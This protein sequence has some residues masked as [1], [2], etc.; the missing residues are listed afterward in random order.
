M[1]RQLKNYEILKDRADIERLRQF[2]TPCQTHRDTDIDFY[3][4]IAEHYVDVL[5]PCVIAV[6]RDG[7]PTAIV[8]G[9]LE[10]KPL[11]VKI[12]YLRFRT[13]RLRTLT[14]LH[15]CVV[16]HLSEED[17]NNVV[18]RMLDF[19]RSGEAT[20]IR[21]EAIDTKSSLYAR[22]KTA[23]SF[24]CSDH[25]PNLTTHYG[26]SCDHGKKSFM[27]SLSYRPRHNYRSSAKRL[28]EAFPGKVRIEHFDDITSIDRLVEDAETVASKTYQRALGVGF[29]NSNRVRQR[30][31]FEARKN[32]LRSYVLYIEEK[33]CA[34]CIGTLYRGTFYVEFIG[35]DELYAKYSVGMYLVINAFN[36]LSDS[37]RKD[38]ASKIDFG[39]GEGVWKATLSS[40]SW[41]E[42]SVLIFAPT[43]GGLCINCFRSAMAAINQNAKK[44]LTKAGL[45]TRIKKL[46]RTHAAPPSSR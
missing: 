33:P 44:L 17:E 7:Q 15:G 2:W 13:P 40:Y 12:G 38:R 3:L 9:R 25:F 4:F 41:Q 28:H 11:E 24:L 20:V 45:L 43:I 36:D 14:L 8:V 6:Y 31:E 22:A 29:S 21:F 30:L 1:D 37:S 46:W 42:A 34:F 39:P 16:G 32:W 10:N 35:Y 27:D 23:P 26:R 19:L 18:A 5:S